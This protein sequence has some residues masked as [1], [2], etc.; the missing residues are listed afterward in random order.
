[1]RLCMLQVILRPQDDALGI[2][3]SACISAV[4]V[5]DTQQ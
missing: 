3:Q 1:M 2:Q 4:R 5:I